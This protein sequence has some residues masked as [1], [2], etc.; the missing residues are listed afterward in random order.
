MVRGNGLGS[1]KVFLVI[2]LLV[3]I[4]ILAIGTYLSLSGEFNFF[5][6]KKAPVSYNSPATVSLK[7]EKP[8]P[9]YQP[10]NSQNEVE[11]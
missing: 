4:I 2:S 6:G 10:V 9:A 5:G 1:K 8:G 7:I 11:K 3:I